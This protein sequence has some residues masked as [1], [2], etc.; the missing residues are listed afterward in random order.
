[1]KR[2]EVTKAVAYGWV[3]LQFGLLAGCGEREGSQLAISP[4]DG[5][6]L[7]YLR[8][9][10][11]ELRG[12]EFVAPVCFRR[13]QVEEPLE[14]LLASLSADAETVVDALRYRVARDYEEGRVVD[15]DGWKLSRGE[16]LLLAGA[17]EVQGLAEASELPAQPFVEQPFMDIE[18]WGP[19]RTIKGEIFNPIGNGRGGFWMRISSPV[20][21]SMRLVLGGQ[22][23]ATHF[24]PGVI[25]ASLEPDYMERI[26]SSPGV[27]ELVLVD[28]SRQLR[29]QVGFLTVV[30]RPPMATRADGSTSEVF[31]EAGSWGPDRAVEGEAFNRQP[32]GA[33]GFWVH[34]GCAPRTSVL[35]LDGIDLPTSVQSG[36]VT[37]RVEHFEE[38][39]RGEH[40]VAIHD[41]ASGET[42]AIGNLVVQ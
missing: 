2:R 35:T 39:G 7:Q 21:G 25:T 10:A 30:E 27:H 29:Q 15:I 4:A 20:N 28:K 17:A 8:H 19:K 24:E 1:M 40:A 31:C 22:E 16:C 14:R 6:A 32:D 3:G 9:L 33:A 37:A 36:L 23:L 5:K 38:L 34:I 12:V 13:L 11:S 42:L 18:S 41:P 26:I